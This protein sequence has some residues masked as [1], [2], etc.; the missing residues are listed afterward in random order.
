MKST[1]GNKINRNLNSIVFGFNVSVNRG[2]NSKVETTGSLYIV[3]ARTK[4]EN[5]PT[6]RY[7]PLYAYTFAYLCN[8]NRIRCLYIN[9]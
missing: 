7:F 9:N 5:T 6:D 2:I 4:C 3:V 8:A 1:I